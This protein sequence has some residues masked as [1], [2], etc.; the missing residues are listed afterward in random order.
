MVMFNIIVVNGCMVQISR[1]IEVR[2]VLVVG[3]VDLSLSCE[4]V[5]KFFV[6][7]FMEELI[8]VYWDMGDLSF[9]GEELEGE[10]IIYVY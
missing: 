2:M 5:V 3:I 8:C 1:D 4:D 6:L 7:F 9:I 10:L